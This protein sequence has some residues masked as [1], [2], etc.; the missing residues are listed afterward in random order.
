MCSL[1]RLAT[2]SLIDSQITIYKLVELHL[3]TH[4]LLGLQFIDFPLA[5]SQIKDPRFRLQT[6]FRL[7]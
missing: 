3:T 6:H 1:I 7:G 5:D 2:H 4:K